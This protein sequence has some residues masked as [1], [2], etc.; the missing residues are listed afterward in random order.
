MLA[1]YTGPGDDFATLVS[2][3]CDNNSG[4]DGKDSR[5]SFPASA[6]TVY[7]IAVD[8]VNNPTTGVPARG[9]VSLHYRLVMPLRLTATAYTN[10]SGGKLTFKVTG[11]PNLV[12]TIQASTSIAG[13]NWTSLVTNTSASGAFNYTN[14]GANALSNRYYRAMNQF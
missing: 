6:G 5:V 4:L 2:V 10:A 7:W 11:T 14:T 9:T 3:A 13:T 1:V 8:G 12:A